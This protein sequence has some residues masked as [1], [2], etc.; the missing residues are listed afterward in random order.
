MDTPVYLQ[1][2]CVHICVYND[3][4]FFAHRLFI[5]NL[6]GGCLPNRLSNHLTDLVC[7]FSSAVFLNRHFQ[8]TVPVRRLQLMLI[9][10]LFPGESCTYSSTGRWNGVAGFK[11]EK[12]MGGQPFHTVC[13]WGLPFG[14][15]KA[16]LLSH[17]SK[18]SGLHQNNCNI[19]LPW[20]CRSWGQSKGAMR[21]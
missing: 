2:S 18:L 19:S 8:E 7:D 17:V 15:W 6:Q 20:Q 1:T 14:T 12:P 10:I 3:M 13:V 4:Y 5:F 16:S 11:I 21:R 9:V